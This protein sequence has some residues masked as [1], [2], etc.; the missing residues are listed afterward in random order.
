MR[1][2][3]TSLLYSGIASA[4]VLAAWPLASYGA[5][6]INNTPGS[7]T[8]TCD[9]ATAPG[10]SDNGGDNTLEITATGRVSGNVVYVGGNDLVDV[11]GPSAGIDGSLDQGDGNNIFRLNLGSITGSVS[12]GSGADVVQISGGQAGKVT[13]GAGIDRFA[14][15]GGTIASLEQGDGLD[16][17]SMSGGTITGAFEDGDEA[18]MTGGTIGRVNMKLDDNRFDMSGGRI[19]GNL[20]TGFGRDTVLISNDAFVG[21]N[22]SV[23][24]GDD[25][26]IISGGTVNGQLLLSFGNDDLVWSGGNLHSS[27]LM[28]E[29]DDTALLQGLAAAQV[30]ATQLLDGG[31]GIDTL[32]LD[33]TRVGDPALF[34]QWENIRLDNGSQMTLGGTLKLGDSA[35]GTGAL[36]IDGSSALLVG[37]G[38]IDPF[39]AGQLVNV[40]N[41]GTL[42]MTT[43]SSTASDTLTINGNYTGN[44]GRLA[45]QT[46]LGADDSASDKLVVSNGTYAGNTG[47]LINNLGGAGA[48]TVRDGILV[49]QALNGASGPESAFTLGNRVSAGAY[50]YYLYKGGVTPGMAENFYLRSTTPPAPLPNPDPEVPTIPVPEPVEGTP[51]LPGPTDKEVPIYRPEVPLYAALFPAAQQIVQ[52]MLGTYHERMGDQSRQQQTGALPA[53]WGRVYGNSSRQSF[54]GTVSPTLDGSLTGFQVG[55]D[56]FASSLDNG[57][58]QRLGFFV[59][60]SRLKGNVKGFNGGWEDKDAGKTTLRGDSLGVYWTL[61]SANRAYLDLMI[62]GTRFD[63]NSESD[64]GVKTKTRGHNV[65]ASAEV[66]L[67]L[68]V[69]ANWV[70]E[71][72]AQLIVGKTKLDSQNDGISDISYDADT[73]VT[74]RLGVRLRGDYL[75]NGMPLQPYV[76]ANVWHASAGDNSVLFNH[77]TR[78]D[79]EQKSTTV[80]VSLG[81]T[82]EVAQGVSLY[83]EIG[84]EK[85]LDSNMLRGRQGTFGLRM[86]F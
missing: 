63:G 12:Q 62:M 60:H 53:G 9:S 57:L 29:G 44:G 22:I 69:S 70:V 84:T 27:V 35:T 46:V 3:I 80:D 34:T 16:V 42:D 76:R 8:S 71:P 52:G 4:M 51:P 41:S 48:A 56:V 37:T 18:T 83:G 25:Q 15:S 68:A 30:A 36:S 32:T 73:N 61:L 82:L 38:S 7:D 10:F 77:E 64:Q 1:T 54:T 72:Q 5:C 11:N 45:L 74:T 2:R 59:G 65:T 33:N 47:V 19:I 86:A 79:T 24:G 43:A 67:P 78:I 58:L 28:G 14:M 17:F 21:G 31:L 20:V 23:S 55:T 39:T 66:G 49:V 81:A 40:T 50:D 26:V 75:V 85:N 6:T 13:Q